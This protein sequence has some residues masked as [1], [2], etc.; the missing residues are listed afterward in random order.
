ME[1]GALIWSPYFKE[2]IDKLGKIQN[3]AFRLIEKDNI[4]RENES[5]GKMRKELELETLEE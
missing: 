5:I 3:K 4:S 2:D 1:Y